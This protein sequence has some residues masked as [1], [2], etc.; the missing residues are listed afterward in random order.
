[1]ASDKQIEW[2][3]NQNS[4][5]GYDRENVPQQAPTT[6]GSGN[7]QSLIICLLNFDGKNP[8]LPN[9]AK[10]KG[11]QFVATYIII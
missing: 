3:V 5:L 7:N 2:K 9:L 11:L 8:T 4:E 6:R 1:M 10:I